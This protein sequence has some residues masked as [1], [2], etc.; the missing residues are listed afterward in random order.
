MVLQRT[1]S[2]FCLLQ[3]CSRPW[4][5]QA[6]NV[7]A[8]HWLFCLLTV[9]PLTWQ[10][11]QMPVLG[12][13]YCSGCLTGIAKITLLPCR[14]EIVGDQRTMSSTLTHTKRRN[15]GYCTVTVGPMP[16]PPSL[17]LSP[18]KCILWAVRKLRDCHGALP[19]LPSHRS[20]RTLQFQK[21]VLGTWGSCPPRLDLH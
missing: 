19:F 10:S 17:H 7:R 16:W 13:Q 15:H 6:Y 14:E 9:M 4:D 8:T 5:L 3:E 20:M 2:F 18:Q 21:P 11:G 1:D 12:A